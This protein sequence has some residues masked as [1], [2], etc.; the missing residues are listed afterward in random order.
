MFCQ[1]RLVADSKQALVEQERQLL[2]DALSLLDE[3]CPEVH[4]ILRRQSAAVGWTFQVG[5]GSVSCAHL[6]ILLLQQSNLDFRCTA[7]YS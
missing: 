1:V 4:S 2:M 3:V 5:K 6:L 7:T